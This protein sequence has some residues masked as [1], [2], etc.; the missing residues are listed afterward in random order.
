MLP[1]YAS[2]GAA[3]LD[4]RACL[5]QPL[6]PDTAARLQGVSIPAVAEYADR[7]RDLAESHDT[8][9][10]EGAGG[11][12]VRLD[13][14][15]GT[16]LD[17]AAALAESLAVDLVVVVGP[18][19]G[20]L[21]HAE[22]TVGAARARGLEPAGL[23]IGSWPDEPGLAERCNLEDLPHHTG[24]PVLATIPAGSGSL[25]REGFLAQS[26]AWFA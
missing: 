16:L 6:A 2:A 11:L 14:D 17:L 15:G 1:R 26:A 25:D 20:A 22:L 21:N 24:L 9:V 10:V 3:G 5:E 23:V 18:Q 7:I 4:L 13:A 19:L 12:L 8:V